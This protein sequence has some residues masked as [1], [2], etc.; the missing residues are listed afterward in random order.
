MSIVKQQVSKR[1][2]L[3]TCIMALGLTACGSDSDDSSSPAV[4]SS[5][6]SSVVSSSSSS[7]Q[8]SVSSSSSVAENT[9]PIVNAGAD[10]MV[11]A[12]DEVNLIADASDSDGEVASMIWQQV[13]GPRT[14]LTVVDQAS[15]HYRFTAPNTGVDTTAAMQFRLTATDDEGA[16]SADTMMVTVSRVNQKPVVNTGNL[17]TVADQAN[18]TLGATA[19]DPD[20]EIVSFEWQQ[21]DG[22]SVELESANTQTASFM[23]PESEQEQRFRFSLRVE[24][25]EGAVATDTVTIVATTANVPVVDLEF[26][27]ANGVYGET[28]IDVFGKVAV[29]GESELTKVTVDAG[30]APVEA[31]LGSDGHWRANNV[32]LPEGETNARVMVSAYDSLGRVGYTESVLTLSQ[33]ARTGGGELWVQST[34]MVLAPNGEEAW[35][36]A[37]GT[38]ESDLKLISIDLSSGYRTDDITDFSDVSLGESATTFTDII[39]DSQAD[40]FYLSGWSEEEVE[41]PAT[42]EVYTKGEGKLV[43]VA[44]SDGERKNLPLTLND[45]AA[46]IGPQGLYLHSDGSFY[47]ADEFAGRVIRYQPE[48]GETSI[49]AD[50]STLDVKV[51]SPVQLGWDDN[52]QRLLA[53]HRSSATVDLVGIN[54]AEV[55]AY[56]TMISLGES[57]SFGPALLE[58][59]EALAVDQ[60]NNRAFVLTR[61]A[62]NITAINLANGE[63]SV[64]VEDVDP[65]GAASKDMVYQAATGLIYVVGG[66]DYYQKLQVVDPESGDRVVVSSSR[67]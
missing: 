40:L 48:T 22:P 17:R 8:S 33:T 7:E 45:E 13:S 44:R 36:L 64:L 4:S 41:D 52:M 3:A 11:A 34:A 15:G 66:E 54:V 38:Q 24:D 21:V 47:I 25:N 1:T 59:S 61:N 55:P 53:M 5:S 43:T 42:G 56:S 50:E 29:V 28:E 67:F 2:L 58:T 32:A 20:G 39:Y 14:P 16:T 65:R 31:S 27:P 49:V 63:R 60:L 12:G 51:D 62:D 26:P 9:A 57:V 19:Y 37:S 18:V 30:V 23:V 10:Q 46:L 35:V 6:S